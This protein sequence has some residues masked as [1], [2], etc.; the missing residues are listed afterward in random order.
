MNKF[1]ILE[2]NYF[3]E[4]LRKYRQFQQNQITFWINLIWIIPDISEKCP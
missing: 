3:F 1:V 2:N 4:N